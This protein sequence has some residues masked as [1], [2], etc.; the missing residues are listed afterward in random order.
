[1]KHAKRMLNITPPTIWKGSDKTWK[2][3]ETKK[4]IDMINAV[5]ILSNKT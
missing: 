2:K 1:M 3:K 5:K 4:I